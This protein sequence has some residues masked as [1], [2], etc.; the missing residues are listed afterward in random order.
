VGRFY[1]N[2]LKVHVK[3]HEC[4]R[5]AKKRAHTIHPRARKLK[6]KIYIKKIFFRC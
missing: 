3:R 1:N 5:C 4:L 6:H 2:G